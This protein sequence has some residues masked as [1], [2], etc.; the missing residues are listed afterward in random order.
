[1]NKRMNVIRFVITTILTTA[2]TSV[3]GYLLFGSV[4]FKPDDLPF[5]FVSFGIIGGIIFSSFGFL[6]KPQAAV[7][8]ILL[9]ILDVI[10]RSLGSSDSWL[11]E[12]VYFI[13]FTFA[14]ITFKSYFFDRLHRM[15]VAR[16]LIA[17]GGIASVYVV[18]TVILYIIFLVTANELNLNLTQMIYFNVAQGFL[19][20][21]GLGAGI[22]TAEFVLN[23]IAVRGQSESR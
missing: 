7:T 23:R 5:Q 15:A 20:G 3:V 14:I 12:A 4:I 21:L 16:T 6:S 17:G 2:G 9:F 19:L 11:H 18:I 13:G 22:E 10:P 1:M 8:F